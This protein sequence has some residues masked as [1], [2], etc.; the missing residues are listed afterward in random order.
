M[1]GIGWWQVSDGVGEHLQASDRNSLLSGR[2]TNEQDA[3]KARIK[4]MIG[5]VLK[6]A[7]PEGVQTQRIT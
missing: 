4:S 1:K 5:L 6:E 2:K 3:S 7:F